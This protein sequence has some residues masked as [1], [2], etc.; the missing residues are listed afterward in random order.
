MFGAALFVQV[1]VA[2]ALYIMVW[3][4]VDENR[5]IDELNSYVVQQRHALQSAALFSVSLRS[6]TGER[7]INRE[8]VAAWQTALRSRSQLWP[9]SG[10]DSVTSQTALETA[11]RNGRIDYFTGYLGEDAGRDFYTFSEKSGILVSEMK[12]L[13]D[14]SPDDIIS[15]RVRPGVTITGREL[16]ALMKNTDALLERFGLIERETDD[17]IL[18]ISGLATASTI[19]VLLLI[20]GLVMRPTFARLGLAIQREEQIR[21]RLANMA[22]LDDLTGIGNR[23]AVTEYLQNLGKS[24][25]HPAGYIAFVSIDLNGFKPV[26]DEFGHQAG[27]A[28]LEAVAKRLQEISGPGD[29]VARMG[30][31]EFA[32]VSQG[33]PCLEAAYEIGNRLTGVF[34]EPFSCGHGLQSLGA[35]IG[36]AVCASLPES[37]DGLMSASDRAMYDVKQ[38][39]AGTGCKVV[40]YVPDYC[41]LEGANAA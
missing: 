4:V 36:I 1:V 21:D 16:M 19:V 34:T 23:R 35:S 24:A 27:D 33:V 37:F 9:G 12:R 8:A 7:Q 41:G 2:I 29:L 5:R 20:A 15:G 31:D 14:V 6:I 10:N 25:D 13:A 3:S 30:G 28:L 38:R 39:R 22:A 17:R 32:I 40:E 18:V 26:N 11:I